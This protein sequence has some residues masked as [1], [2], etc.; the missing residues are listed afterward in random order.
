MV[1]ATLYTNEPIAKL[2]IHLEEK[3]PFDIEYIMSRGIGLAEPWKTSITATLGPLLGYEQGSFNL[4]ATWNRLTRIVDCHASGLSRKGESKQTNFS[5]QEGSGMGRSKDRGDPKPTRQTKIDDCRSRSVRKSIFPEEL[6]TFLSSGGN[7]GH[8]AGVQLETQNPDTPKTLQGTGS[9]Q[10]GKPPRK[11]MIYG[12]KNQIGFQ[13]TSDP[14]RSSPLLPPF[15]ARTRRRR[16]SRSLF[17]S[18]R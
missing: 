1:I 4:A 14:T 18:K 10:R 8:G 11:K 15:R 9:S 16:N 3:H 5:G 13:R 2:I 6:D 12:I 17:P 7:E